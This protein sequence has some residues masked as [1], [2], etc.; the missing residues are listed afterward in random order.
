[1]FGSREFNIILEVRGDE[2]VAVETLLDVEVN[3]C[4]SAAVCFQHASTRKNLRHLRRAV[5]AFRQR[6]KAPQVAAV[7]LELET[8]L[9]EK[10]S[11]FVPQWLAAQ[12]VLPKIRPLD[13]RPQILLNAPNA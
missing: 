11:A 4:A 7:L 2:L 10:L 6:V 9:E 3:V 12:K 13:C 1:M 5:R 8:Q